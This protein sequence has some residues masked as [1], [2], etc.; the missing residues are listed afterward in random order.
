MKPLLL[1]IAFR[2]SLCL[3]VIYGAWSV[4]GMVGAVFCL[5]L[6]GAALISPVYDLVGEW[7]R[8]TRWLALRD[9][10]GHYFAYKGM[11]LRVFEDDAQVRW[12]RVSD[13]QKIL[14]SKRSEQSVEAAFPTALRRI[15]FPPA[16]YL[17]CDALDAYLGKAT[18]P[19]TARFR[20]W[21]EREI[22]FPA[23]RLRTVRFGQDHGTPSSTALFDAPLP[24]QAAVAATSMQAA[25]L[26]AARPRDQD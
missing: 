22:A 2:L 11:P 18:A 13:L 19:R 4:F 5:P 25:S 14:G 17:H 20:H 16:T 15:G 1:K 7:V 6:F 3:A 24:T 10:Q 8:L 23:R 26:N 12:L 21:V 9:V